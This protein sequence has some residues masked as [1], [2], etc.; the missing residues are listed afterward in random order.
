MFN[1]RCLI[2]VALVSTQEIHSAIDDDTTDT[3]LSLALFL[4]SILSFFSLSPITLLL[5]SPITLFPLLLSLSP[6][7]IS[8]FY[9][10]PLFLDFSNEIR[11]KESR[12]EEIFMQL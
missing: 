12:R 9:L 7:T 6:I 3:T 10:P 1:F 11:D 2:S 8:F 5:L 4:S